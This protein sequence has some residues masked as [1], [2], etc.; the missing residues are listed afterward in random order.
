MCGSISRL[1]MLFSSSVCLFFHQF[2]P[3]PFFI[4]VASEQNLKLAT[5]SSLTLF[6]PKIVLTI[7]M[8]LVFYVNFRLAC[9]FQCK[10][11]RISIVIVLN[12]KSHFVRLDNIES[13]THEQSTSLPLAVFDLS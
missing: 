3:I 9:H 11:Y 12:I 10:S 4:S 6:F 8:T 2:S 13:S 7:Q 5:V 1:S